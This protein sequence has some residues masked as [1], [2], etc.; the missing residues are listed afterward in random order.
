MPEFKFSIPMKVRIDD[1]NYGNHVGYQIYLVYFQQARIAYLA[2]FGFS[3]M[4]INGYGMIISEANC[5][6]K[7]ELFFGDDIIIECRVSEL[8][9]KL[10]IMDY[11]IMKAA[12]ICALGFTANMCFD[13]SKKRAVSLPHDFI[14]L[15][16]E[17][18]GIENK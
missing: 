4:N 15:I 12:K 7:Q 6:Y 5:R 3:E 2:Q 18:E 11:R 17:F 9:S 10:F 16:Q 14:R 1:L 13:Y 8:K